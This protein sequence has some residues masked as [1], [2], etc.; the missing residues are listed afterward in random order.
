MPFFNGVFTVTINPAEAGQTLIDFTA[1]RFTYRDIQYWHERIESGFLRI[2]GK[3]SSITD[4]LQ[5]GDVVEH[6][7]IHFEEPILPTDFKILGCL[8]THIWVHKPAGLPVHATKSILFQNLTRLV[9]EKLGCPELQPLH[10]LDAETSGSIVFAHAKKL[11][12]VCELEDHLDYLPMHGMDLNLPKV[13][14]PLRLYIAWVHGNV[15][16][17]QGEWSWP[18]GTMA[19]NEIRCQMVYVDNGKACTTSYAILEKRNGFTKLALIPH[20]GRKHQLRAHCALA[21]HPIVGDKI[22]NHEGKY[23]LKRIEQELD[24]NDLQILGASHHLL[25]A[26]YHGYMPYIRK[27]FK[28]KSY[29][30]LQMLSILK[31]SDEQKRQLGFWDDVLDDEWRKWES[32][33]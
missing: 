21:G 22:Y 32:Q 19:G 8:G 33:L 28:M 3:K 2:A 29:S 4:V 16:S 18:L 5:L 15:A 27:D 26:C 25:H 30:V 20:T 10:R 17:S 23:Y 9:R 6:E 12:D 7:V 11:A 14:P 24:E 1:K 13:P 31:C